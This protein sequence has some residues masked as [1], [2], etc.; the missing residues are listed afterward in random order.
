MQEFR[1]YHE[2]RTPIAINLG[3]PKEYLEKY[4]FPGSV[5]YHAYYGKCPLLFQVIQVARYEITYSHYLI[6]T[7]GKATCKGAQKCLEVHFILDGE[8][9]Y[10]LK[11]F[12]W[13]ILRGPS[14][15]IIALSS[16][17]NEVQF[18]ETPVTTFDI[19]IAEE[20]LIRLAHKYPKLVPLVEAFKNNGNAS[21]FIAPKRTNPRILLLIQQL[22]E[23]LYRGREQE[24]ATEDMVDQLLLM[25]IEDEPLHTKYQYTYENIKDIQKAHR[26]I[27]LYSDES[28]ILEAKIK[29][30]C[31]YK[32]KFREAFFLL[33]GVFP[34]K[35][36]DDLQLEKAHKL[37]AEGGVDSI[38]NIAQVCGFKSS[39][40][41]TKIFFNRYNMPLS[42]LLREGKKRK[43]MEE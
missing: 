5:K 19:H 40:Y 8:I 37:A 11:G 4:G 32:N 34:G 35:Y 16:V 39:S 33:Y 17:K 24:K 13:K 3:F 43:N 7:K 20:D 23:A 18:Q 30:T 27:A 6:H 10:N 31:I 12:G 15:N 9:L 28:N 2:N 29:E 22:I 25:V 41:L 1:L 14:H 38:K 26:L 36:L 21:L 42:T